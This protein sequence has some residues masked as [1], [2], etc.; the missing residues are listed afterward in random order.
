MITLELDTEKGIA[1]LR[2]QGKLE[3]L[4]FQNL[5]Q[6]ADP[7]IEKC[8]KLNGLIIQARDF[9]GWEDFAA[10]SAHIQFVNEHHKKIRKVAMVS[11]SSLMTIGP[12]IAAHFVSAEVRHFGYDELDAAGKWI[13]DEEI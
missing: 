13:T 9:P 8:G 1:I 12:K 5:A 11:D 2:P 7:Y 10:L 3:A 6:K 4:D